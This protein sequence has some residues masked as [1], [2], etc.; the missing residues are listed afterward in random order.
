MIPSKV[1]IVILAIG[2]T[3]RGRCYQEKVRG[4]ESRVCRAISSVLVANQ[5]PCFRTSQDGGEDLHGLGFPLHDVRTQWGQA[6]SIPVVQPRVDPDTTTGWP[7][8]PLSRAGMCR[9][10]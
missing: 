10:T 9:E 7:I 2:S 1:L 5:R 4:V 3:H 8:L 6:G